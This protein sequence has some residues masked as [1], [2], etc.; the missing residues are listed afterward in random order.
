[1]RRVQGPGPYDAVVIGGSAGSLKVLYELL[2]QLPGDLP[3][4]LVVVVH[5]HPQQEGGFADLLDRRCS[6]RIKE[7]EDKELLAPGQVYFAPA[8][9]HLLIEPGQ[10]LSLSADE[11]VKY[12]RPSIDVLFESAAEAFRS[13]LIGII[14]TGASDDGAKGLSKIK[15]QRGL[16]VVQDPA[17][18]EHPFMP[19]AVLEAL[20]PDHVLSPMGIVALLV[21]LAEHEP[22]CPGPQ[23]LNE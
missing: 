13:R 3:W 18:A 16:T 22:G 10:T 9:Y 7:A 17:T 2:P 8:N 11:R 6:L 1:M 19:Q 12:S 14:L 5:L 21:S 4:P 23:T 15:E 20:A